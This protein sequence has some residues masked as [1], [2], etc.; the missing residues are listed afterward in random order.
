MATNPNSVRQI[1]R[2]GLEAGLSTAQIAEQI[3][4]AHPNTRAAAIPNKHIGWYKSKMKA[5]WNIVTPVKA[6][7]APTTETAP[8]T[9]ESVDL[10]STSLETAPDTVT[11]EPVVE[12]PISKRE[13]KRRAKAAA[14]E[15]AQAAA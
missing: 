3:K 15:A 2:A 12:A 4:A 13:A 6:D 10:G 1:V 14:L 7:A 8:E 9:T 11:T 5:V